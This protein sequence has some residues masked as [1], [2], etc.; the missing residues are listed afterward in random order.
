ME[1]GEGGGSSHE[2]VTYRDGPVNALGYKGINCN[3]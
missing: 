2:G 3:S 1:G